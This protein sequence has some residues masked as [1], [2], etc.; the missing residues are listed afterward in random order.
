[1][2]YLSNLSASLG[3][4]AQTKGANASNSNAEPTTM[5][6]RVMKIVTDNIR[7]IKAK[8]IADK[9]EALGWT[10]PEGG[11]AKLYGAVSGSLSYLLNR[12]QVLVKTKKGYAVKEEQK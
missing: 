6:D 5:I 11:R 12:K 10:L 9:Y 7:P 2:D 1:M 4:S 8:N 3:M